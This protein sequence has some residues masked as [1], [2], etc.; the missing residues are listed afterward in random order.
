MVSFGAVAQ[1]Y[2]PF[3][4]NIYVDC[5]HLMNAT[6]PFIFDAEKALE[7]ILYIAK[8]AG[9]P[10]IIHVCKILYFADRNHLE[11]FGRFICGDTYY[12]LANG[13]VPTGTYNLI[14]DVQDVTRQSLHSDHARK[15]FA[16]SGWNI[17]PFRDAENDIFSQSDLACLDKAIDEYGD[18]DVHIL[19]DIS[20]DE[21]Y[22]AADLNGE[23]SVEAIAKT[24]RDGDALL[25]LLRDME[26][27]IA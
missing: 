20:H 15:N 5:I 18:L 17:R 7:V 26:P 1:V 22:K 13:P 23:I 27:E 4:E 2:Q 6:C 19:I 9:I 8:R 12:A 3:L 10:D 11:E 25:E 24:L 14:R 16:L 21:A